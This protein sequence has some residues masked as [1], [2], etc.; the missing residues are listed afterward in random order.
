MKTA[1]MILLTVTQL[2]ACSARQAYGSAQAWQ[3]NECKK[4]ID[5][6]DYDRCMS[7]AATDYETYRRQTEELKGK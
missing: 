3:R 6:T 7:S 1:L 5:K 4:L 2:A